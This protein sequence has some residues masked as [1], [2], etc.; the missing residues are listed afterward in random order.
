MAM[1]PEHRLPKH[2]MDAD[3]NFCLNNCHHESVKVAV[4]LNEKKNV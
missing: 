2:V 1:I 4:H 3:I